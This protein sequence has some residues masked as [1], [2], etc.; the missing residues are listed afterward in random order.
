MN[1]LALEDNEKSEIRVKLE[2]AVEKAKGACERLEEKTMTAAKAADK[3]VREHPYQARPPDRCARE[4]KKTR[5]KSRSVRTRVVPFQH[6]A[7]ATWRSKR[8]DGRRR[9]SWVPPP[10]SA[11]QGGARSQVT[12]RYKTPDVAWHVLATP[13]GTEL[14]REL[15]PKC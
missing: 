8:L 2:S 15:A 9:A 14:F 1:A 11:I 6:S 13:R 7:L 10:P 5:L 4:A 12:A 3:A